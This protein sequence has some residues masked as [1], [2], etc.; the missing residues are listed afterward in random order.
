AEA[1]ALLLELVAAGAEAGALRQDLA[2]QARL[3]SAREDQAWQE[4]VAAV[5]ERLGL[6]L[7]G[8]GAAA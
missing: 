3:F 5:V 4:G 8:A 2:E 6:A 7:S 1:V